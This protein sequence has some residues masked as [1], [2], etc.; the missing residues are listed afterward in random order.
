M[1]HTFTAEDRAKAKAVR[2]F[3]K[4]LTE[5][6]VDSPQDVTQKIN[7]L[8]Q[9]RDKRKL[10][11]LEEN[12]ILAVQLENKRMRDELQG[13]TAQAPAEKRS[14]LEM[15]KQFTEV[16]QQLSTANEKREDKI[17]ERILEQIAEDTTEPDSTESTLLK[18]LLPKLVDG[19]IPIM[20]KD[21]QPPQA[22]NSKPEGLVSS[23]PPVEQNMMADKTDKQIIDEL[24]QYV[25]NAVRSGDLSLEQVYQSF[26][27]Q[28]VGLTGDDKRK[29]ERVYNTIKDIKVKK[30]K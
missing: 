22:N 3:K 12:E 20:K 2:E 28:G 23:P 26:R 5:E 30:V 4:Q 19:S 8:Q 17:K 18:A 25:K 11:V 15:F 10:R 1:A 6:T 29:L 7:E 24:P 27:T 16:Q 9:M 13:V 21:I 14:D